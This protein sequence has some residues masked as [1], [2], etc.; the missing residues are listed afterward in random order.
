MS[1]Y[2]N[3][4]SH[5]THI[6]TRQGQDA[7]V[8]VEFRKN[9]VAIISRCSLMQSQIQRIIYATHGSDI[10]AANK[11]LSENQHPRARMEFLCTTPYGE[12]DPILSKVFSYSQQMFR[13]IYDLRNVL[14][15]E[16]WMTCDEYRAT[17]LFS[18]IE[19]EARL[20]K[21]SGRLQHDAASNSQEVFDAIVRYICKI[22]T[23]NSDNLGDAVKDVS[24][25][26]WMLM[27][28]NHVLEE[29]DPEKKNT[30]KSAFLT[31]SGTSHLFNEAQRK[32]SVIQLCT[33]KKS[34][35]D[36]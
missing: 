32:S 8:P 26:E 5:R 29:N 12:S 23:I 22:K 13:E 19:E 35:I 24:L 6:R 17:V 10:F 2:Y 16:I 28:I 27:T 31:F 4:I 18:K 34:R 33:S 25:C 7:I 30:L 36:R 9:S 14:A 20:L 1:K 15:H 3:A 21:A 11:I